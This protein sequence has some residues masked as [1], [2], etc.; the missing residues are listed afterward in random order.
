MHFERFAFGA[1][2]NELL[3]SGPKRIKRS[4]ALLLIYSVFSIGAILP[5]PKEHA[6]RTYVLIP[7]NVQDT[8]VAARK[9][10]GYNEIRC[11]LSIHLTRV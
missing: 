9:S 3:L 5:S 4:S 7:K 10:P 1:D 8:Q 11:L 6:T 2:G